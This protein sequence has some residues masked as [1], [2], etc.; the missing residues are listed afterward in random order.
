PGFAHGA[1]DHSRAAETLL[2]VAQMLQEFDPRHAAL[3]RVS[4]AVAVAALWNVLPEAHRDLSLDPQAA[5]VL[6]REFGAA[7]MHFTREDSAVAW[8]VDAAQRLHDR[9]RQADLVA[10]NGAAPA[11]H[12]DLLENGAHRVSF[13]EIGRHQLGRQD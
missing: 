12:L 1:D 6:H 8:L 7:V 3:D 11:R 9:R 10:G 5:V 4:D 13:V 2:T